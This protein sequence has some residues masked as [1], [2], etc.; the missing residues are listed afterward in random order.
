MQTHKD[1]LVSGKGPFEVKCIECGTV[2]TVNADG[3]RR[4]LKG[5]YTGTCRSCSSRRNSPFKKGYKISEKCIEVLRS[6]CG[7]NSPAWKGGISFQKDYRKNKTKEWKRNNY[8]KVLFY[9]L[10][11]RTRLMSADGTHSFEEWEIL[12]AQ[13]DFTCVRCGMRE[14]EIKLTQDHIIPLSKGGSDNI[15]NIQ[16][17]CRSCNSIKNTKDCNFLQE[18]KC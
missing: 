5:Y 12:K 4:I 7:K 2:R 13:Y 1:A 16:P 17:L 9:N 15:E 18:T 14:P 11:R 8:D 6:H 10:K 3:L